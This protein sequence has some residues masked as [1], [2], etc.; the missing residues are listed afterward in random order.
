MSHKSGMLPAGTVAGLLPA[1]SHETQ[2]WLERL[3]DATRLLG[4][5]I[6]PGGRGWLAALSPHL[7]GEHAVALL[8][9]VRGSGMTIVRS[10][11]LKSAG[12]A[13]AALAL[14][15]EPPPGGVPLRAAARLPPRRHGATIIRGYRLAAGASTAAAPSASTTDNGRGIGPALTRLL[16]MNTV[17]MAIVSNRLIVIQ[18]A[19]G[20]ME[21]WLQRPET[22]DRPATD[23]AWRQ[24]PVRM[25]A[26]ANVIGKGSLA[27]MAALRATVALLPGITPAQLASLPQVGGGLNWQLT[28]QESSLVWRMQISSSEIFAWSRLRGLDPELLQ[29]MISQLILVPAGE[30]AT[31]A[32]LPSSPAQRQETSP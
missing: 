29:A 28:R 11:G 3:A 10:Y 7:N 31:H 1:L 18:G 9:A 14:L 17:E 6:A 32:P 8:P 22:A 21:R 16:D 24:P 2:G 25:A 26:G 23:S 15:C 30:E 27:A 19:V 20:D 13:E 5:Q 4:L 12:Q